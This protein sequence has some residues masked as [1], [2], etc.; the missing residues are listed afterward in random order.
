MGELNLENNN[1]GANPIE[2]SVEES[3]VHP[4]YIST[5]KYYDIA[6]L[7]LDKK[8]KFNNHIRPA[9]LNNSTNISSHKVTAT[10][11]GSIEYGNRNCFMP[12]YKQYP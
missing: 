11:W 6:L 7:R 5:S 3:I 12:Y 2:I 10:G 8:V 9:C 1:D 4:D